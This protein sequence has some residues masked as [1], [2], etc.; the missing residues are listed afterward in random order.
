MHAPDLKAIAVNA[1]GIADALRLCQIQDPDGAARWDDLSD[2]FQGWIGLVGE[3]V[4]AA[5]AMEQ[6]RA[7]L[8]KNTKWGGELPYI[9][10]VWDAIAEL[11]W[12]EL[13]VENMAG[14]VARAVEE[15]KCGEIP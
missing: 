2:Q 11:L 7:S 14:V 4:L 3:F 5:E 8:G 1:A 9:Y 15:A 13:P 6:H 10:D 12:N